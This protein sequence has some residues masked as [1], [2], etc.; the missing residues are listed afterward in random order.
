MTKESR[1]YGLIG[2]LFTIAGFLGKT[3]YRDFVNVNRISDYGFAGFLPSYF[4]VLG[5]SLLLLIR[6][7]RYPKLIISFVTVA[8]ILF[9]IKQWVSTQIFDLN[10]I[11]ASIAGGI[12]AVLILK[13]IERKK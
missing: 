6:P 9:E 3:V 5:F 10:D 11:I 1:M 4:Y 13:L 7:T 12:T 2:L 8:S